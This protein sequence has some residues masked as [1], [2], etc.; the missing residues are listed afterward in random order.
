MSLLDEDNTAL[1]RIKD[2]ME[3][4]LQPFIAE[5]N[6]TFRLGEKVLDVTILHDGMAIATE[7]RHKKVHT[8][9]ATDFDDFDELV[10]S[11]KSALKKADGFKVK[12]T[13]KR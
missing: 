1:N 3:A 4:G 11:I 10:K 7:W 6:I 5:G 8:I 12:P 13:K 9:Y 2:L